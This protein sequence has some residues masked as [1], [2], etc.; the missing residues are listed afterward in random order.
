MQN[1]IADCFSNLLSPVNNAGWTRLETVS[2]LHTYHVV[3]INYS[4]TYILQIKQSEM[5]LNN[6]E[7]FGLLLAEIT[8]SGSSRTVESENIG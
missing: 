5:L 3:K 7:R 8:K 1:I 6:S 4:L 2:L